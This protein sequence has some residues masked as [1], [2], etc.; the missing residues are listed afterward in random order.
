MTALRVQYKNLACLMAVAA[1]IA[2]VLV[3]LPLYQQLVGRIIAAAASI[4]FCYEG[5]SMYFDGGSERATVWQ[6]FVWTG[7][8]LFMIG[9]LVRTLAV[10]GCL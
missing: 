4:G 8:F 1:A 6:S 10:H 2:A 3:V 5:Y 7:T 9:V